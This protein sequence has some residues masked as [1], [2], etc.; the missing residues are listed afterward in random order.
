MFVM[1]FEIKGIC[2]EM[3]ITPQGEDFRLHAY[4]CI[5]YA[6]WRL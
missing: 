4:I 6:A 5:L 1:L 3:F 2:G